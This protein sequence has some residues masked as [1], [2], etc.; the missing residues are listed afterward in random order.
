MLADDADTIPLCQGVEQVSN[1]AEKSCEPNL[2]VEVASFSNLDICGADNFAEGVPS[3]PKRKNN[4]PRWPV[5]WPK[6]S[7]IE[8][9][10][11]ARLAKLSPA[12]DATS[13]AT[14]RMQHIIPL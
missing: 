14:G 11:K 7:E 3:K 2:D 6:Q 4:M 8:P 13:S 12:A 1:S 10:R 5:A 9:V